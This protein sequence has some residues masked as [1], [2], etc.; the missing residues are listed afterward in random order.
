M[1][2]QILLLL[3]QLHREQCQAQSC[4]TKS[5]KANYLKELASPKEVC[6]LSQNKTCGRESPWITTKRV[7]TSLS[8]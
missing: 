1:T 3:N 4:G 2:E 8:G 6:S 7:F 5:E